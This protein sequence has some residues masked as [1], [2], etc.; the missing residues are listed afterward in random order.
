MDWGLLSPFD[1]SQVLLVRLGSSLVLSYVPGPPVVRK[2]MQIATILPG[3]VAVSVIVSPNS[4][5]KWKSTG[6]GVGRPEFW[7]QLC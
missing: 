6:Q 5:M 4:F 3:Q 1:L 7:S 2:L